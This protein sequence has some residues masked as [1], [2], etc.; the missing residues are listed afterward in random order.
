MHS[1][2][3]L[4]LLLESLAVHAADYPAPVEGN[5]IIR[6]FRFAS[7]EILL[8]LRLHY[9]TIGQPQQDA[10][11]ILHGTGGSGRQFLSENFAGELFGRGQLLD[12]SRHFLVLPDG[13]GHGQSSK[14]SDGLR[15]R[16]PRYGYTDLVV[17]QYRLLTEHFRVRHLRLVMG[18]SM[19]GMHTWMWG[20]KYPDLMD[21]LMPLASA[22][23]EIAGL[24]RIR[25]RIVI[26]SI[27]NDPE[28]KGGDYTVQ[29][30]GLTAAMYSLLL[31]VA[32][33][34]QLYR[35]APTREAADALFDKMVRERLVRA[36]ANDML[37]AYEASRDYNPA[38]DLEKIQAPLT[39]INSAD[40]LVN[41]P[42]LGILEREIRRVKRG[43]YVLLP[44]SAETRGHGTH[45]LPRVWKQY[46]EELLGRR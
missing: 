15:A 22:P 34:A 38:P 9:T 19:G 41:P 13:I 11:L 1:R 45:S 43:R 46:L 39:A 42:E 20:V 16:F 12:G 6:D 36:D 4:V 26:D 17:A 31:M 37:Y 35:Q 23:V 5:Y 33:P 21:A 8:E 18:T 44:V 24:N 2:I 3:V 32:S 14:P 7:G 40:D 28:R 10:V 25:R 30:R 29:P 27:R